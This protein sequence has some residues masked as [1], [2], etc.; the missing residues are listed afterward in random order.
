VIIAKNGIAFDAHNGI[1]VTESQDIRI[2]GNLMEG[3]DH[4]GIP[5]M[6]LSG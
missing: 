3:S 5:V 4:D 6:A 1:Y 2:R